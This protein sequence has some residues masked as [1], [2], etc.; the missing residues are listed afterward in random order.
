MSLWKLRVGAEAYYLDQVASGL[1]DYYSGQ[2]ETVGRWIGNAASGLG[3]EGDVTGE[4]L[5]AVLAGLKPGTG[6]TPNSENLRAHPRRVPGFDL[7]FSVPKSVSVAY[8]LG[9]PLVQGAVVEASEVAV[10][11]AVAWLE[12]EAC[13]VRR[14]TNRQQAKLDHP[15]EWGTR[16]LP[17][18]GFVAA[19]FRHRTSRAGDPQLHWH[20]LVANTTVGPDRRWSALDASGLYRSQRAAGVIFQAALRQQLTVRLGV[21]WGPAVKDSC[22]I[23]GIPRRVLRLFSKRR[24]EIETELERLGQSGARAAQQA[25]LATR[26][27]KTLIDTES[28]VETWQHEAT[29]AGWGPEQLDDLL[30][31]TTKPDLRPVTPEVLVRRLGDRLIDSD[32]TFTRHDVAQAIAGTLAGATTPSIDRLTAGVLAHPELVAIQPLGVAGEAGWE[33]R[34]TT[35][36]LIGLESD[37]RTTIAAGIATGTGGLQPSRVAVACASAS[38]GPDQHDAVTRLCGQGN[39]IEVLVGRAGTGKTYTLNTIATAY[40]QNGWNVIGVAPSARAAREL[41]NGA[42]VTSFT[43]PRFHNQLARTPLTVNTVV[44][45]D[46]AGMCGT[47]DLHKLIMVVRAA[48]AKMILVGDNH[49]LPEIQA[50]GGL[51]H[52]IGALGNQTCEL[53][54]N[55]RQTE[56]W[57]QDALAHL[58]HGNITSAWDAYTEHARVIVADHPLALHRSVINDWWQAHQT[59]ANTLLLAGTRA[60]AN[61]LNRLA[62]QHAAEHGT[63]TGPELTSAGRVFQQG[64]R[65]LITHNR[66]DQPTVTGRRTRIDNGMLGTIT[67]INIDNGTVDVRLAHATVRLDRAYLDAGHLDH[68]YA[69][70][71]HKSQGTTCDHVYVVGPAGLYREAAYVALSRARHGATLYATTQ[72]AQEVGE[73]D[74]T[75][76]LPLPGETELPEHALLTTIQRTHAKTFATTDDPYGEHVANLATLPLD[77]LDKRL[78]AAVV[79]ESSAKEAGL[80]DPAEQQAA[81]LRAQHARAHMAVGRRVRALDRN[82]VGTI[83]SIHDATGHATVLFIANDNT[84]AET[85]LPWHNLRPIDHPTP[86]EISPAA[87]EWLDDARA[88]VDAAASS[89]IE[90]LTT[91]GINPGDAALIDRA[92][93]TREGM[94]GQQLHAK[95]PDWLVWWIGNRPDD[96]IGA[97]TWD[98]TTRHIATWRDRHHT[99]T[100]QPGHGPIPD[101]PTERRQWLQAMTTTLTQ[102][103]WLTQRNPQPAE[104]PVLKLTGVEIHVRVKELE[105]LFATAPTDHANVVDDIVSGN[106]NES[107]RHDT[108]AQ[109]AESPSQRDRWIIANWPHIVEHQQL[110]QLAAEHDTLAH[111]PVEL[112]PAAEQVLQRLAANHKRIEREETRTIAELETALLALDPAAHLQALTQE[113]AD[114]NDRISA[115]ADSSAP[116][117]ATEHDQLLQAERDALQAQRSR[118]RSSIRLERSKIV[119]QRWDDGPAN[120]LRAAIARRETMLYQQTIDD[121]PD[122]AIQLLNDLDD[123][124]SLQQLPN[125][126]VAQL[127][128][129]E[130]L[131]RDRGLG[132]SHDIQEP[133]VS[134][135][136]RR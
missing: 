14:G 116:A 96:A 106:L 29:T 8:A 15:A 84:Q 104:A 110:Q 63:L 115:T 26:Q 10:A 82:N 77:E 99:P 101:D 21:E 126:Q 57:E 83:T 49:Q 108:L 128:Q 100:D 34:Y 18:A 88:N 53:T 40:R 98:D 97:T 79:A 28:L 3:L 23:A 13:H 75:R 72:Q 69:M 117:G 6:L 127:L 103:A 54:V 66:G 90:H 60:E 2:G 51:T 47:V 120:Q 46:E 132:G 123:S 20:V 12:R 33:E 44:V 55:R 43:I 68:G 95:S 61:A 109:A 27:A 121:P 86:V 45:V 31:R 38:L 22:E 24:S 114:V 35:L 80:A 122:W 5:R 91:H 17:G 81:L 92:I 16:R 102:R 130:T 36:R 89:W 62:R 74:H 70:T 129:K 65:V 48:G 71:I 113:L 1:D 39:A 111:P 59:G 107:E 9:D 42:S 87:S 124:G 32:A 64:D 25:T 67:G 136:S 94:L 30:G 37:I 133:S 78:A 11:E 76:G 85:Q 131:E 73:R 41:H 4:D 105:Q 135:S 125:H 7:T 119:E 118:M 50:G 93:N 56:P 134:R 112:R 52:A 58:R 19:Q